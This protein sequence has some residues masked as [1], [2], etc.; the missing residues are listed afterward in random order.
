MKEPLDFLIEEL[1]ALSKIEEFG[2]IKEKAE[3]IG[4]MNRYETAIDRLRI[5]EEFEITGGSIVK[6]LPDN[7]IHFL[8]RV[9]C[10][11]ESS[12]PENWSEVLFEN[13]EFLLEAEDLV[14]KR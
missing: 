8:Y 12:N 14:I 11:N 3:H 1:E 5:C 10:E 13:R 7:G 9:V 4:L 6:K 2:S